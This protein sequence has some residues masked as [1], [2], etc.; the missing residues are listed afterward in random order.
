MS[1][2]LYKINTTLTNHQ[3]CLAGFKN[4]SSAD[5]IF[6]FFILNVGDEEKIKKRKLDFIAGSGYTL[7]N[8]AK[9]DYIYSPDALLFSKRFKEKIGDVLKEEIQ[10]FFLPIDMSEY[11]SGM[12]C[13]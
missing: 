13:C 9:T 12:V 11:K 2:N 1:L 10:F 3:D 4:V 8:I 5:D 6:S 7:E